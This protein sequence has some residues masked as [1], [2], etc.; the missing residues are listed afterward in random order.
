[1][2]LLGLLGALALVVVIAVAAML[3][4]VISGVRELNGEPDE[5]E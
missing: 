1:M 2:E 5:S 3:R 4:F